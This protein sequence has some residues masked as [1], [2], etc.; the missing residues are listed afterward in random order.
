[1]EN[2]LNK[3]NSFGS[4]SLENDLEKD[5]DNFFCFNGKISSNSSK[6]K[7][8][9]IT[10]S[11]R[12]EELSTEDLSHFPVFRNIGEL[13]NP[14]EDEHC[15][16]THQDFLN[17]EQEV[18]MGKDVNDSIDNLSVQNQVLQE[19]KADSK[20]LIEEEKDIAIHQDNANSFDPPPCRPR[21]NTKFS[22]K[23]DGGKF[24]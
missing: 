17:N 24:I 14:D 2:F 13:E 6:E 9:L 5:I 7:E 15:N 12:G 21:T 3:E 4:F 8:S 16:Y 10:F 20:Q 11:E 1:M 18:P 23:D 22:K 19:E